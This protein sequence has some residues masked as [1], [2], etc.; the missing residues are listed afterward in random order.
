M[1]LAIGGLRLMRGSTRGQAHKNYNSCPTTRDIL[2]LST[3]PA[4]R[5]ATHLALVPLQRHCQLY[6]S[7]GTQAIE[8]DLIHLQAGRQSGEQAGRQVTMSG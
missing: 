8:S 4:T 2:P 7:E 1:V 6:P 3:Q 5:P